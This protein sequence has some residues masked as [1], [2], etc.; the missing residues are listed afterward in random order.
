MPVVLLGSLVHGRR[1]FGFFLGPY[2]GAPRMVRFS[3]PWLAVPVMV[4]AVALGSHSPRAA[5]AK[6][7]SFS[8][9]PRH[10]AALSL[11]LDTSDTGAAQPGMTKINRYLAYDSSAR[12]V[13]LTLVAA[14]NSA[15]GG[16]NFNGGS[17]GNQTITV[18]LGWSIDID[19]QN[20][21]VVPHSAVVIA[22]QSPLPAVPEKPAFPRAYT[23][24][25]ID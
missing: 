20:H 25:L 8:S 24:H 2:R 11:N 15:Q 19:F 1:V 7:A 3:P 13:A 6:A 4:L 22:D 12:S 18:P 23:S 14:A 5:A 16:F 9:T 21:D 10:S 17:V